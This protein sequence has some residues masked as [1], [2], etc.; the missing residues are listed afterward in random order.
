[1]RAVL[2]RANLPV[3]STWTV[4]VR[5]RRG[6]DYVEMIEVPRFTSQDSPSGER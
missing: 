2:N 3:A 6:P 5:V 1:M 4:K